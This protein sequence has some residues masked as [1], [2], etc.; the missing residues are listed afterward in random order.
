MNKPVITD[1]I[2]FDEPTHVALGA[3]WYESYDDTNC[4]KGTPDRVVL[5]GSERQCTSQWVYPVRLETF[6]REKGREAW[7]EIE[8]F[9]QAGCPS[10]GLYGPFGRRTNW[11]SAIHQFKVNL[12]THKM[13]IGG[14]PYEYIARRSCLEGPSF[15]KEWDSFR[16]AFIKASLASTEKS[17]TLCVADFFRVNDLF[18]WN[19]SVY[20]IKEVVFVPPQIVPETLERFRLAVRK[21]LSQPIF[22]SFHSRPFYSYHSDSSKSAVE[23]PQYTLPSCEPAKVRGP[24]KLVDIPRSLKEQRSAVLE[25]Y[26]SLLTIRWIGDSV[27]QLILQD[28]RYFGRYHEGTGTFRLRKALL[29]NFRERQ[30][31]GLSR[32]CY[33]RDFKKEGLT[34]PRQ[35]LRVIMEE[36]HRR[37][38]EDDC[39]DRVGFFDNWVVQDRD[40]TWLYPARGHGLGMANSMTTVMQIAIE[41]MNP[42]RPMCSSYFNDDAT[43]VCREL[44]DLQR[45]M[46]EDQKICAELGL[47]IKPESIKHYVGNG[48]MCEQ[49]FSVNKKRIGD[50]TPYR[51]MA[52][53]KIMTAIN[54]AHARELFSSTRIE[55]VPDE[56]VAKVLNYWGPVLY[57]GEQT[58]LRCL[59][60]WLPA[61]PNL[62]PYVGA[63][64]VNSDEAAAFWAYRTVRFRVNCWRKKLPPTFKPKLWDY[65]DPNFLNEIDYPTSISPDDRFRAERRNREYQQSWIIY[66][67]R[68]RRRFHWDKR[69]QTKWEFCYHHLYKLLADANPRAD[70]IPPKDCQS[71]RRID[72]VVVT[73]DDCEFTHPYSSAGLFSAAW[74]YRYGAGAYP[75]KVANDATLRLPS[76]GSSASYALNLRKNKT[77]HPEWWN[78]FVRPLEGAQDYWHNPF[79]PATI[80]FKGYQPYQIIPK[81]IPEEK[82][83]LLLERDRFYRRKLTISEWLA[84]ASIRPSD[85]ILLSFAAQ[86]GFFVN[87]EPLLDFCRRYPGLGSFLQ[88]RW[89]KTPDLVLILAKWML[90]YRKSE[91]IRKPP[92][93]VPLSTFPPEV[94]QQEDMNEEFDGFDSIDS[95]SGM[96]QLPAEQQFFEE[97]ESFVDA[98]F[99]DTEGDVAW[100]DSE[101]SDLIET[102]DWL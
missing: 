13:F 34:K 61:A 89:E 51:I 30:N 94:I 1:S 35:I 57:T 53:G 47:W 100:S 66:Q 71:L 46:N 31:G 93:T 11:E 40:G 72:D 63:E 33:M 81:Y 12:Y 18:P 2:L 56:L 37:F 54:A 42:V 7:Q 62:R 10:S 50:K 20:D 95:I 27:Q 25:E 39:F 55:G 91:E 70:V 43:V 38:P 82:R 90:D 87:P 101:D 69:N 98:E 84:F 4:A 80:I 9:V 97:E 6:S 28:N 45:Y 83:T 65:I 102:F 52:L 41:M 14:A 44:S 15:A 76:K 75:S 73:T 19:P 48:V 67:D 79:N 49:Y 24:T 92:E 58:R 77:F 16:E 86:L 8:P 60:G 85:E 88:S 17:D 26:S 78:A 32:A 99:S 3:Q 96:E 21:W 22:D 68:L 36:L 74:L 29:G 64:R 59:G 23:G 5:S